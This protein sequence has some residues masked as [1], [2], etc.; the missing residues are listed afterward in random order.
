[1]KQ[2]LF[3]L[4]I[5]IYGI[6]Q[7]RRKAMREQQRKQAQQ[8][9][10]KQG[11]STQS[12]VAQAASLRQAVQQVRAR[13][14]APLGAVSAEENQSI[15]RERED[16]SRVTPTISEELRAVVE[17][18]RRLKQKKQAE[19]QAATQEERVD[20]IVSPAS[21]EAAYEIVTTA[22]RRIAFDMDALRTFV[23][24]REVLGP[25][26]VRK[27]HRPGIRWR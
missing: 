24:T 22:R 19:A 18:T 10:P 21:S 14:P 6:L 23:V 3:L 12:S 26:R 7:A 27:P 9:A 16:R 15:P 2:I 25:P 13:Q 11:A 5:V 20:E 4:I 17:S 8:N 1:M